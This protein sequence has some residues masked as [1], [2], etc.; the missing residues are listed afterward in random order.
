[1]GKK[2]EWSKYRLFHALICA[3]VVAVWICFCY[4]H[5]TTTAQ[6]YFEA[7]GENLAVWQ[8]AILPDFGMVAT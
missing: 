3:I 5:Y 1:M 4:W 6:A 8:W 7:T 2:K